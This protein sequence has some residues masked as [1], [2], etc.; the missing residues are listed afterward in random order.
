MRQ[1]TNINRTRHIT[2][3]WDH[4]CIIEQ[5]RRLNDDGDDYGLYQ[6]YGDHPSSG[7]NTLLYIGRVGGG[8][9]ANTD[10]PT[11][12]NPKNGYEERQMRCAD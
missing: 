12:V 1:G 11:E 7:A 4:P 6:I 10:H 5:V 3:E 2:I 9:Q 8:E